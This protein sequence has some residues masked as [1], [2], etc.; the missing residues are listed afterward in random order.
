MKKMLALILSLLFLLS[1]GA[2]AEEATATPEPEQ[3]WCEETEYI[4]LDDGTAMIVYSSDG[5]VDYT[6]PAELDGYPVSAI[7]DYAYQG[8]YLVYLVVPEGIVSIGESAFEECLNLETVT[9]PSTLRSIGTCAFNECDTLE[10]VHFSEGL[11][12]I[13]MSVFRD[14]VSLTEATLP[15][16]VTEMEFGV[17]YGCE[18][19]QTVHIPAGLQSIA[20][21]TFA[22]CV[23]LT[24]ITI[25]DGITVIEDGAFYSCS[26][27][28]EIVI[29]DSVTTIGVRAFAECSDLAMV[30]LPAGGADVQYEAFLHTAWEQNSEEDFPQSFDNAEDCRSTGWTLPEGMKVYT[31]SQTLYALLPES[32]RTW[33]WNAADYML[34]RDIRKRARNDYTGPANNTITTMYLCGRDGTVSLLYTKETRPPQFG[35]VEEGKSLD[36]DIPTYEEIWEEIKGFFP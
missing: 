6:I 4:L 32:V 9:L 30:I 24:D 33:D 16:S 13:G 12:H 29:P 10:E 26:G 34:V 20:R 36:G 21:Y 8:N 14:C 22:D 2:F 23:S 3:F 25:P 19:L 18:N 17:F 1:A 35:M 11:E 15:D 7:G 31:S 5:G 27:L 28:T